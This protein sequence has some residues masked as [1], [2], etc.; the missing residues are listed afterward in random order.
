MGCLQMKCSDQVGLAEKRSCV[1]V[2]DQALG[3]RVEA[4]LQAEGNLLEGL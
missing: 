1:E 3:P 2:R 4:A